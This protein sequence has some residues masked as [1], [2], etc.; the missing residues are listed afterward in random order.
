[1]AQIAAGSL[2]LGVAVE[3]FRPSLPAPLLSMKLMSG[4]TTQGV[5][6]FGAAAIAV[7]A[8]ASPGPVAPLTFMLARYTG[9]GS[10]FITAGALGALYYVGSTMVHDMIMSPM[11][12]GAVA[13]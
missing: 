12:S 6:M 1:M 10:S 4:G 8:A 7:A 11:D 9:S 5:A 3:H 13:A 2:A